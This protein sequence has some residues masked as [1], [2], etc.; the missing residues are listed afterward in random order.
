MPQLDTSTWFITITSMT[1]TLFIMF[2]L[3][4]SKHSYPSNPELKPINTSMHTTPWESK[5]TKIYSPLSLP[6]Q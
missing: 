4:L 3:K 1:I 2:Q 5:W 6:Q